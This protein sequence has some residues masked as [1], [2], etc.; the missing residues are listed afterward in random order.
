MWPGQT[1]HLYRF[2]PILSTTVNIGVWLAGGIWLVEG[3]WLGS[4]ILLAA[5]VWLAAGVQLVAGFWLVTELILLS[6]ELDT[7]LF[8]AVNISEILSWL[9]L[10]LAVDRFL[11]A[12]LIGLV[13][14]EGSLR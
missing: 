11:P 8:V 10:L 4:E 14:G 6:L 9:L 3:V 12:C 13:A 1:G 7:A 5:D 2:S